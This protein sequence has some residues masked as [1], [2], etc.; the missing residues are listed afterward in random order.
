[1]WNQSQA[2]ACEVPSP[3]AP[4]LGGAFESVNGMPASMGL[5]RNRVLFVLISASRKRVSTTH[6]FL[7]SLTELRSA[8]VMLDMVISIE[9]R[10]VM[11]LS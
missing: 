8:V 7:G 1:M 11:K 5:H 6:P 4:G 3:N 9:A 2:V 10:S